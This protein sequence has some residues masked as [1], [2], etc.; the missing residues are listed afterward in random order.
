MKIQ[1]FYR[2]KH[3][4]VQGGKCHL[5]NFCETKMKFLESENMQ[6]Y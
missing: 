6:E 1:H 2:K 4:E 3:L 5:R